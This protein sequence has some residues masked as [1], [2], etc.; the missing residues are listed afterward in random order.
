MFFA[1]FS[2]RLIRG[3]GCPHFPTY[4]VSHQPSRL[5]VMKV[6]QGPYVALP[7]LALGIHELSRLLVTVFDIVSAASPFPS[8]AVGPR[9]NGQRRRGAPISCHL[10]STL[11]QLP[12]AAGLGHGVGDSGGGDG[13]DERR[14]PDICR[15]QITE[16]EN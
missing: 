6:Y 5:V 14:L 13:V 1:I 9:S 4:P 3:T 10:A 8:R 12:H 11:H 15:Q 7:L 16:R 2:L